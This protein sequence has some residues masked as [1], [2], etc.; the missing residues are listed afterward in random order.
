MINPSGRRITGTRVI[1]IESISS[2]TGTFEEGVSYSL[3]G[4]DMRWW[5]GSRFE[6]PG[7]SDGSDGLLLPADFWGGTVEQVYDAGTDGGS[8]PNSDWGWSET[9]AGGG[10]ITHAGNV[11]TLKTLGGGADLARLIGT[12]ISLSSDQLLVGYVNLYVPADSADN[13]N[14]RVHDGTRRYMLYVSQGGNKGVVGWSSATNRTDVVD[15]GAG[16]D[17]VKLICVC[18]QSQEL[19]SIYLYDS[20]SLIHAANTDDQL[21]SALEGVWVACGTVVGSTSE[22]RIQ[23]FPAAALVSAP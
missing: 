16:S 10:T 17:Y 11:T 12:G 6:Y 22:V 15:S 5:D 2:Y 21:A 18:G 23:G 13:P 4:F 14:W 3:N 8:S 20:M 7:R 9:A 1:E 19:A